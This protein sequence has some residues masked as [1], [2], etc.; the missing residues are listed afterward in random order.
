MGYDIEGLRAIALYRVSTDRQDEAM[1]K[2]S[3]KDFCLANHVKLIEE[4][5][6]ID[7][8]GFKVPLKERNE[9]INILMRAE[10]KDFDL[11]L[12]YNND[13][14]T[15]R[16]DEAP[17]ILQVLSNNGIRVFETSSNNEIRTDSHMDKLINFFNSWTAEFESIKTSMRV[18]SAFVEKNERG[19]F[20]GGLP[21]GYRLVR[22]DEIN[23]K[24]QLLNIMEV[25]SQEAEIVKIIFDLYINKNMGAVRIANYLNTNNFYTRKKKYYVNHNM[26]ISYNQ[27]LWR[28]STIIRILKNPVYIGLKPYNKTRS[29]RDKVIRNS[30]DNYKLQPYNEKLILISNDEFHHVQELMQKRKKTKKKPVTTATISDNALCSGL[31]YCKCGCKLKTGYSY[32]KYHRKKDNKD[33]RKKVY[34]YHCPGY[35]VNKEKHKEITEKSIYSISKYD[36]IIDE[37]ILNEIKKFN[38]D[39]FIKLLSDMKFANYNKQNELDDLILLREK[40]R[41]LISKYEIAID[42][43]LSH[44]DKDK[45]DIFIR[46]IKRNKDKLIQLDVEIK[47]LTDNGSIVEENNKR[48]NDIDEFNDITKMYNSCSLNDK[49]A[50]ISKLVSRI[51]ICNDEITIDFIY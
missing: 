27:Y 40:L 6:E 5:T 25:D 16:S 20:L 42:E 11:L 13:R 7:V 14:L 51:T 8:S 48:S 34:Y 37:V 47:K 33:I 38:K 43:C 23:R 26:D 45:A 4:C 29:T 32:S 2:K 28:A 30:Q 49:K 1:Q 19:R 50:I 10:R 31:I 35:R 17:Q 21:F 3:C 9:L 12:I 15:R 44:D 24:G 39:N 22:T 18:K 46:N 41:N 36:T